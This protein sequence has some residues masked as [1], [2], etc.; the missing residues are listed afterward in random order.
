MK[1]KHQDAIC[2]GCGVRLTE[3]HTGLDLEDWLLD[4]ESTWNEAS[5][6]KLY[7]Y[8]IS[9]HDRGHPENSG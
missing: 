5:W 8:V 6:E 1:C 9:L 2:I 7:V 4:E 3:G